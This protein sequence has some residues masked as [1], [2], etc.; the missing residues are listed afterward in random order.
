MA[1]SLQKKLFRYI[2][3]GYMS[4]YL[5]QNLKIIKDKHPEVLKKITPFLDNKKVKISKS[6]DG[7][8]DLII[9]YKNG[10]I[11]LYG[12]NIKN[13]WIDGPLKSINEDFYGICILL[14]FGLGYSVESIINNIYNIHK[15]LI[16]EPSPDIFIAALK[17]RDLSKILSNPKI[18]IYLGIE[19][20]KIRERLIRYERI[21]MNED[22]Y[23]L[24]IPSYKEFIP[25]SKPFFQK[26]FS[27]I[28]ELN[29]SGATTA[30][31]GETIFLNKIKNLDV[32][33]RSYHL[34]DF[35]DIFKGIPAI[36]VAA[37][38]SL[39]KNVEL[40]TKV[41]DNA[42][43]FCVDTS[44]A[45]LQ[46]YDI[47]PHFISTID[48][49]EIAYQKISD[50]SSKDNIE[51]NLLYILSCCPLTTKRLP[52]KRH[53]YCPISEIFNNLVNKY[54][55]A[56]D[57]SIECPSTVAH[58]NLLVAQIMGN[59]PIIFIGQDLTDIESSHCKDTI[60]QYNSKNKDGQLIPAKAWGGGSTFTRRN[61][62]DMK[63]KFEEY[64]QNLPDITYIN[65]TE[66][67]VHIEG[68][69]D[70][71][72]KQV[73]KRYLTSRYK[74]NQ[75]LDN[76]NKVID[77]N[78]KYYTINKLNEISIETQQL[79]YIAN[80]G[81]NIIKKLQKDP[82]NINLIDKANKLLSK[83]EK[84][85]ITYLIYELIAKYT[86]ELDR[87]KINIKN[88]LDEFHFFNKV[89]LYYREAFSNFNL[90]LESIVKNIK[91]E[92]KLR[93]KLKKKE[94]NIKLYLKLARILYKLES[95]QLA[96]HF[97]LLFL[98]YSN[99]NMLN[100]TDILYLGKTLIHLHDMERFNSLIKNKA[101]NQE[102]E[103]E[104]NLLKNQYI[105]LYLHKYLGW[106]DGSFKK[107]VLPKVKK[108]FLL[109][110][111]KLDLKNKEI[112]KA[113]NTLL[114]EE[115]DIVKIELEKNNLIECEKIL[116]SW[117]KIFPNNLTIISLL[118]KTKL[119]QG[120]VIS[121]VGLLER[122]LKIDPDNP[123]NYIISASIFIHTNDL[124]KAKLAIE[125]ASSLNPK[126]NSYWLELGDI[127]FESNMINDALYAYEKAFITLPNKLEILVKISKCYLK[128]GQFKAAREA[129]Y[130]AIQISPNNQIIAEKLKF[131]ETQLNQ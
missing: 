22:I 109:K 40:L 95:F 115:L 54:L 90:T 48:Y 91:K 61:F 85:R 32:L 41:K 96:R 88:S 49:Q 64:I 75:I 120:D 65:A 83:I 56:R 72:F 117:I 110:A 11:C 38:P 116:N 2:T 106:Q 82:N 30:K 87:L 50:W 39:D 80:K 23:F 71:E 70:I 33:F 21:L 14:G 18:E 63:F 111:L 5:T 62:W 99:D 4:D 31:Q 52:V 19:E 44:F 29:I 81:I 1:F 12:G 17:I 118:S 125:K 55:F 94:Q 25:R 105:S 42:V 7:L 57:E 24:E 34:F 112:L 129:L 37:G 13:R 3:G 47:T 86:K 121:A 9:P 6:P 92:I 101:F 66:G 93:E 10:N 53:I 16:F 67:G 76:N 27:I 97:Y 60:L 103:K 35:K 84:N 74:I 59:N 45:T 100:E 131:L 98:N 26:I 124:E 130:Q 128:L 123:E 78:N 126:Y 8:Y 127:F 28:N 79:K 113:L 77:I 119:A 122:C 43:I 15:V 107:K 102:I 58:L 51:T 46:K 73:I 69:I 68:S 20:E 108:H 89:F 114:A 36:L 104:F